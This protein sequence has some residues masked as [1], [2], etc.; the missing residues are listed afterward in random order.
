MSLLAHHRPRAI[1]RQIKKPTPEWALDDVRQQDNLQ[2]RRFF[3]QHSQLRYPDKD[4]G[5]V[6]VRQMRD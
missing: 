4:S 5:E 1:A 3:S 2:P 6:A